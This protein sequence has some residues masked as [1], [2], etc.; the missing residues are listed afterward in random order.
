MLLKG[1]PELGFPLVRMAITAPGERLAIESRVNYT[2]LVTVEHN[3]KVFFM[4]SI[5]KSDYLEVVVKAVDKCWEEKN[6]NPK[7]S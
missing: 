3:V 4:R 2:K 1:E 7:S 6:H 5:V